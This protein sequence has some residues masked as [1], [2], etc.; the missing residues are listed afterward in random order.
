MCQEDETAVR[1]P[2]SDDELPDLPPVTPQDKKSSPLSPTSKNANSNNS[3]DK[4]SSLSPKKTASDGIVLI[5]GLEPEKEVI[6]IKEVG[7]FY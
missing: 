3:S 4:I 5:P 7:V 2:D 6:L 1:F